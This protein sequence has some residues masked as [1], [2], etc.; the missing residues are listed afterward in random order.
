MTMPASNINLITDVRNNFMLD[1][2]GNA[3]LNSSKYRD[4][5]RKGS[6]NVALMD[7][8]NRALSQGRTVVKTQDGSAASSMKPYC[9][10]QRHD[11]I[12]HSAISWNL[13]YENGLPTWTSFH[14]G[15][16]DIPT[17]AYS[18][19]FFKTSGNESLSISFTADPH[20]SNYS[21]SIRVTI[22]GYNG[23]Y[24]SG[25]VTTLLSEQTASGSKTFNFT[26][27]SYYP[28]VM[29]SFKTLVSAWNGVLGYET[30]GG[31]TIKNLEVKRR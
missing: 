27:S 22:Y 5:A 12:S 23:G 17:A 11:N 10:D 19:G 2:S 3:S 24:L 20:A 6:G 7:F 8:A 13:R 28:Y 9:W 31:Y 4:G 21:A 30:R 29:I 1:S 16:R 18:H 14:N 15:Y 26:A 25:D